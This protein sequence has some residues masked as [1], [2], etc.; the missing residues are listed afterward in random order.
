MLNYNLTGLVAPAGLVFQ[1][2]GTGFFMNPVSGDLHWLQ[3]TY[4]LT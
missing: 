3:M 2:S 4:D 1:K